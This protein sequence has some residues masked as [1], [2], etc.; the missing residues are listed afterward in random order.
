MTIALAAAKLTVEYNLFT[1]VSGN[2]KEYSLVE[3]KLDPAN[4]AKLKEIDKNL[5]PEKRFNREHWKRL[6][7]HVRATFGGKNPHRINVETGLGNK[8]VY[9]IGK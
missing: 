9:T 3:I 5:K 7:A 4:P 8:R 6:D 2:N 1:T